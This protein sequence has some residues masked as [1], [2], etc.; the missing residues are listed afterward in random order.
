MAMW[1]SALSL[2]WRQFS[3]SFYWCCRCTVG[4][5]RNRDSVAVVY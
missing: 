1:S 2:D 3:L 5:S 4:F